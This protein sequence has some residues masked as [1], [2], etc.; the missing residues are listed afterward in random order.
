[1]VFAGAFVELN[2]PTSS[3]TQPTRSIRTV[4]ALVEMGQYKLIEGDENQEET[5]KT[6]KGN[7]ESWQR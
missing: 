6:I 3:P 2:P 7:Q 5:E 1:M 4:L